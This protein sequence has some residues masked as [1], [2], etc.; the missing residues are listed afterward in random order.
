[1]QRKLS[2]KLGGAFL[3]GRQTADFKRQYGHIGYVFVSLPDG[4]SMQ[5]FYNDQTRLFVADVVHKNGKRGNEFVRATVP[6]P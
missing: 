2:A 1:M 6:Q 5:L 3:G 4:S